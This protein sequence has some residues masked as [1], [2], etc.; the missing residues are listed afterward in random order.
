MYT[1]A[2]LSLCSSM[3]LDYSWLQADMGLALGALCS[4]NYPSLYLQRMDVLL[5]SQIPPSCHFQAACL[6]PAPT[7][8]TQSF[9]HELHTGKYMYKSTQGQSFKYKILHK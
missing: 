6:D 8:R 3:T 9:V 5:M 4:L 7:Y 2:L 1:S